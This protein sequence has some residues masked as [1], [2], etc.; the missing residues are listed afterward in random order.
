MDAE[1]RKTLRTF[2]RRLREIRRKKDLTQETAAER[3]G[4][5]TPNYAAIEQGRENITLQTVARVAKG[6]GIP[7]YELF[8]MPRDRSPTRIGRPRKSRRRDNPSA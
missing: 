4:M 8:K 5:L 2:G 6:F 3:V 1:L 7:M